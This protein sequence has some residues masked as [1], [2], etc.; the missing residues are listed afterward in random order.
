MEKMKSHN[1]NLPRKREF[2]VFTEKN[3]NSAQNKEYATES[4]SSSIIDRKEKKPEKQNE[5]ILEKILEEMKQKF[6]M[7]EQIVAM[8]S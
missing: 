6:K 5:N 2:E 8:R 3:G 7:I 4:N 1:T